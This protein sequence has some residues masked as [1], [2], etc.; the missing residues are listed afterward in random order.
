MSFQHGRHRFAILL[1][2]ALAGIALAGLTPTYAQDNGQSAREKALEERVEQLEKLVREL[3]KRSP[4]TSATSPAPT[5]GTAVTPVQ[6][7]AVAATATSGPPP[8]Q[9]TSVTPNSP[10]GTTFMYTGYVKADALFTKAKNGEIADPSP[11]RDYYVP[12]TIPIGGIP[13]STELNAHVKQTRLQLGTDTPVG[14]DKVSTRV[15]VDLFGTALGDRRVTN[16]YGLQ[17]RHAY[18]TYGGLLVGQTWTNFMDVATLPDSVDYIGAND[19]TI[20]I[21]QPQVRY[22]IAG[23]TFSLEDPETTLTPNGGGDRIVSNQMNIPDVVARY[24]LKGAWG[25]L[26]LAGMGRQLK[27]VRT[28]DPR[29]DDST[30]TGAVSLFGKIM[31]N[32]D[33]IRFALSG[34]NLGRYAGLNFVND[35]VIDSQGNLKAI[36]GVAG[37]IAYRHVWNSQLRSSV[38][39]AEQR[40]DNN[41]VLTGITANRLSR[42]Y[43]ANLWYAPIPKL[44]FGGELLH[45]RRELENGRSGSLNR[46][47]LTTKYSF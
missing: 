22:S 38:W 28:T 25:Q 24:T 17:L 18:I 8:V 27:Y 6:P 40:Y 42:S 45:G 32:K 3:G 9:S 19:G 30:W 29:I 10:S 37:F 20:F 15:E 33:D 39:F 31:L 47:E 4:S 46:V 16:T 7:S 21:R 26:S 11:G 14:A 23:F 34:G 2:T 36:N 43:A 13:T 41:S 35:G 5:P 12:S 44:E 1:S